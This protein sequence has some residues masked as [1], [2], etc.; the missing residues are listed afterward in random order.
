MLVSFSQDI[1]CLCGFKL[2]SDRHF[3]G[4]HTLLSLKESQMLTSSPERLHL[5]IP[6]PL[7]FLCNLGHLSHFRR[8]FVRKK[9]KIW[10]KRE[11]R[12]G[13]SKG[14]VVL[15][16]IMLGWSCKALAFQTPRLN[17]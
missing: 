3:R 5:H 9:K 15:A 7:S 6:L 16:D 1:V 8:Q 14:K 17:F 13:W 2:L 10:S 11:E 4:H 12:R